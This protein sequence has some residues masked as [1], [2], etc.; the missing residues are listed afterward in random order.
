MHVVLN[1]LIS[2]SSFTTY[3]LNLF[4]VFSVYLFFFNISDWGWGE[5][6]NCMSKSST[7]LSSLVL[8]FLK[9]CACPQILQENI[10]SSLSECSLATCSVTFC[11]W[12]HHCSLFQLVLV[13]INMDKITYSA[14]FVLSK[15]LLSSLISFL[16]RKN[17]PNRHKQLIPKVNW[18]IIH[19]CSQLI[20]YN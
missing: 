20:T 7:P 12:R 16:S 6:G 14:P 4:C 10:V 11:L 5:S 9:S 17:R 18:C 3:Y 8:K 15:S 19:C 2:F 13:Q 1:G